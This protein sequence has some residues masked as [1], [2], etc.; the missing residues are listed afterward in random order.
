MVLHWLPTSNNY[1]MSISTSATPT[2]FT[3]ICAIWICQPKLCPK[4]RVV[5]YLTQNP[6]VLYGAVCVCV[7]F[8]QIPFFPKFDTHPKKKMLDISTWHPFQPILQN[9]MDFILL[10]C[11]RETSVVSRGWGINA[12]VGHYACLNHLQRTWHL[13]ITV[14]QPGWELEKGG[15]DVLFFG[16]AHP[17]VYIYIYNYIYL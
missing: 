14:A 15:N 5:S 3:Q 8:P 10:T 7:C 2:Y 9:D 13:I 6:S 16:E 11:T 1:R 4:N 17:F 12:F